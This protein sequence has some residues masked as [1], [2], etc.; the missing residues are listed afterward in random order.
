MS[1]RKRVAAV[2]DGT[3]G[4]FLCVVY[5]SYYDKLDYAFIDEGEVEIRLDAEPFYVAADRGKA[6]RVLTAVRQKISPQAESNLYH[7]FLADGPRREDGRDDSRLINLLRYIRLGFRVGRAV[8]DYTREPYVRSTQ[9]LAFAAAREAQ[10]LM[11]FCRFT[12]TDQGVYYASVSPVHNVLPILAEHFRD[13]FMNQLWIIHD[14]KRG[15]AA[16]Y[17]GR[18]YRVE[19]VP[20]Q[21]NVRTNVRTF[22]REEERFQ[23]LWK[24]FFEAVA[25]EERENA[26][27]QRQFLPAR[28]RTHMTEFLP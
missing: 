5:S 1:E 27:L 9:K 13:R 17:D 12:L 18:D 21:A 16:V 8:D 24:A 23:H 2:F 25:V 14:V 11:G 20:P 28:Y 26:K 4:G 10:R 15:K 3:Y 7:A 6:L 22:V 19:C